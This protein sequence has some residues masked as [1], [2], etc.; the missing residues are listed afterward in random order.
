MPDNSSSNKKI[1]KNT[2]L[3]YLRMFYS[4]IISLFTA[5][6]ILNALGFT[7]Y[8]LYNVVGSIATMFIFLRSAMGNSTNRYLTYTIGKGDSSEIQKVFSLS[9]MIFTGLALLIIILCETIGL[10]FFYEK[11][12]IPEDRMTAAFWVYQFS[13]ITT[14]LSVIC[15]PYDAIIIA[16]ERMKVFAYV[17]ILNTTLNLGIVYLVA[18]SPFDRLIVYAFLLMSLQVMN[19]II[20]GI[21][22]GRNFPE[23]KFRFVRD[24]NLLKEMTSFAGWSLVGNLAYVAYNQGMN[25]VLNLFFGPVVNAARAIAFNVQGAIKGFV[26]NFQMAVT[27]Q[28]IKSYSQSDYHR[29]HTLVYSSSKFSFFLLYCIVLP[30]S[31][32]ARVILNLWLKNVPDYA[33]LFTILVLWIMLIEPLSNPIDKA[34]QATGK[35]KTYQIVEGGML[36]LILPL[37]YLTL[38]LGAE[39]YAVFIVQFVIMLIVQ[40]LRLFLVCHK[41]R[42]SIREYVRRVFVKVLLVTI[43][44]AIIPTLLVVLLPQ[45]FFSFIIVAISSVISVLVCSY[46]IG[47]TYSEKNFVRDKTLQVISR[48]FKKKKKNEENHTFSPL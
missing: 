25:I 19:R 20:Y 32:E 24:R 36:L 30:I 35:I 6:V 38:K 46:Y 45:T 44:A 31:L 12:T 27:P 33:V 10:W 43:T 40:V 1:A 42:M 22:C 29:L 21:Y 14:A 37:A 16:H 28:I 23:T 4:F 15:V 17:Q 48:F 7:D 8:G 5:R 34:N 3:L 13:I 41:I 11:L 18:I 2:L 47:L 9:I 39:P 26:A